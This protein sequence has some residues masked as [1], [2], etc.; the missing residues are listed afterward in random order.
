[1]PPNVFFMFGKVFWQAILMTT[2]V[3][4]VKGSLVLISLEFAW[5]VCPCKPGHYWESG[6]D[7]GCCP[8]GSANNKHDERLTCALQLL[9]A[10]LARLSIGCT[11][12]ESK[13]TCKV[14]WSNVLYVPKCTK[15]VRFILILFYCL[16][17]NSN[18][19]GHSLAMQW[20]VC[21]QQIFERHE[22]ISWNVLTD[23]LQ[24]CLKTE[25]IF[26]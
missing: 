12:A 10:I 7:M 9:S 17:D 11:H 15:Q 6:F 20:K 4:N 26:C 25:L 22:D 2:G 21:Q 16:N 13:Q 1:M 3:Y 5:I 19:Y 14:L 18:N 8:P 23:I 24:F